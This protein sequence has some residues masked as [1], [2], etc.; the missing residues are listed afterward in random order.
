MKKTIFFLALTCI[1]MASCNEDLSTNEI[2]T[3]EKNK[4]IENAKQSVQT[5]FSS[6]ENKDLV[7][8]KSSFQNGKAVTRTFKVH[9]SI[10]TVEAV[11][12]SEECSPY[13]QV[14]MKGEGNATFMGQ[15]SVLIKYCV[16]MNQI[17]QSLITADMTAANGDIV[18]TLMTGGGY[19]GDVHISN[20]L[21]I[22]GTGRFEN[23]EGFIT[24]AGYFDQQV[25]DVKGE[26]EITF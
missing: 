19:E 8:S 9:R 20:Y 5:V 4:M 13:A 16:D 3:Q 10:G 24:L 25:F 17:P 1:F 21:I 7:Q 15:F 22:G 2:E 26:G 18:Y 14:V 11:Y 23:A 6:Y 12:P